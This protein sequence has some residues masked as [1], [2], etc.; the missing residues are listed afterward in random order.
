MLIRSAQ[1]GSSGRWES[2]FHATCTRSGAQ[3]AKTPSREAPG[4]T[5]PVEDWDDHGSLTTMLRD[6]SKRRSQR[7]CG[8]RVRATWPW[9]WTVGMVVGW[10]GCLAFVL[11]VAVARRGT[12]VIATPRS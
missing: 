1:V 9:A 11:L 4:T 7:A 3:A 5:A 6:L 2:A 12:G 8:G 10:C